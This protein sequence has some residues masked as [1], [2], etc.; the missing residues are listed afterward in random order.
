MKGIVVHSLISQANVVDGVR[1]FRRS[2]ANKKEVGIYYFRPG[3]LSEIPSD[4]RDRFVVGYALKANPNPGIL[5]VLRRLGMGAVTVSGAEVRLARR[6][7]FPPQ[8]IM[9]NGNGKER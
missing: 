9:Y 4:L 7:G 2:E 5:D 3:Y 1:I 8:L 6:E